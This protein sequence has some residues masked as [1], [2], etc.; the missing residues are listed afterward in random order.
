MNKKLEHYCELIVDNRTIFSK[1]FWLSD[2]M[3]IASSVLYTSEEKIAD[4]DN[5]KNSYKILRKNASL[6]SVFRANMESLMTAKM[7]LAKDPLDYLMDIK[8]IYAD[9]D[10]N[11]VFKSEFSVI[12]SM[13]IKDKVSEEN[14]RSYINHSRIIYQKMKEEHSVITSAED[15]VFATLM[16]VSN[17][18]ED[19]LLLEMEEN[20]ALLKGKIFGAPNQ[21]LSHILSLDLGAPGLKVDRFLRL[22]E[23]MK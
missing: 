11:K 7:S 12:A 10:P 8:K 6:L 23:L 21:E 1:T 17:L 22:R 3:N 2:Y 5:L 4:K 9:L 16:A 14:W 18:D 13:I 19:N 15:I 20:Y